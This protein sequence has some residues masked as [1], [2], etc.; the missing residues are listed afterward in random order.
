MLNRHPGSQHGKNKI[1]APVPPHRKDLLGDRNRIKKGGRYS[2]TLVPDSSQP[3]GHPVHLSFRP[4]T[5]KELLMKGF[6]TTGTSPEEI[7]L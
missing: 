3:Q 4:V 1:N 2:F 5:D 7:H 6:V